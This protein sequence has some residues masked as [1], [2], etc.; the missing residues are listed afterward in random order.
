MKYIIACV[1]L[2]SCS[3][4]QSKACD[5][6]GASSGNQNLG[7]LPQMYRHF[8]GVQYQYNE[9]SSRHVPLSE[10]RPVWY[11]REHY[12][13]VQLWG[14]YCIGKR[15]QLFGFLPYR[16][17]TGSY[18]SSGMTI[19][20][21]GDATAIVNYTLLQTADSSDNILRHRLQG[22]AGIKIPLGSH[23]GVSQAE[24][25]GLPN[26]QPGT[27][28]W[29]V[30]VNINYTARYRNSGLNAD[31]A[32][33]MTTPNIL[34]YKYGNRLNM[35]VSL[36][37]WLQRNKFSILPQAG[38]RFEYALHDYD[39]YQR[40]WLNEQTGGYIT[41]AVAGVQMYYGKTGLQLQYSRPIAQYFGS[42]NITALQKIDAGI[43]LLF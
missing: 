31:L 22:G 11:G 1:M 5:V 40:K 2:L 38:I 35:Q 3:I 33:V 13:T 15:W 4:M 10:T 14:R 26:M 20:G 7:L 41:S 43:I 9:F 37:Y 25:E 12:Q 24:R 8:V 39:N 16:Y 21:I 32:Y 34:E 30:P 36:F 42:G 28:S 6:C 17:N 29:D 19:K 18:N 23:S 27:G